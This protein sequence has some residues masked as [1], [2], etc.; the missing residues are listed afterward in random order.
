M[1]IL[2]RF[3]MLDCK[4]MATLMD[5]HLKFLAYALLELVYVTLYR[6]IIGLLM[7]LMNTRP[8][9]CFVMNTLSQYLVKPRHVHMIASKHVMRYL[10]VTIEIGLY[11]DRD[12]DYKLYGYTDSYLVGSAT[13]R[14]GTSGGCYCPG[15]TMIS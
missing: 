6:Q 2:R 15:S 4:S 13:K 14:K 1:E 11:Y 8:Y 10:K 3:D 12:H 7:Y 5:T 9:I